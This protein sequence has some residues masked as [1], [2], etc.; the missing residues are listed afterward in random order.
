MGK[1]GHPAMFVAW[2]CLE[3]VDPSLEVQSRI[4][5]IQEG[6]AIK[7]FRIFDRL[8]SPM[9][10]NPSRLLIHAY[11]NMPPSAPYDAIQGIQQY[12]KRH[13]EIRRIGL[14]MPVVQKREKTVPAAIDRMFGPNYYRA[15]IRSGVDGMKMPGTKARIYLITPRRNQDFLNRLDVVFVAYAKD[16]MM[17]LV[18]NNIGSL[19]L[20]VALTPNLLKIKQWYRRYRP[21]EE[22]SI[23]MLMKTIME[24]NESR[25]GDGVVGYE[26]LLSSLR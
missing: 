8:S 7:Q 15:L 13:G 3:R 18:E 16:A 6:E 5:M 1:D 26:A 23:G 4:T 12:C 24:I 25:Y 14:F 20:I 2:I 17:K 21:L 9:T 22:A 10:G 19:S 11:S